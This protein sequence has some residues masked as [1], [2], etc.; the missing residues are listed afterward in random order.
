M[1][2][3]YKQ[4]LQRKVFAIVETD[5]FS[6]DY[7][8]ETFIIKDLSEQAANSIANIINKDKNE[9]SECSRYYKVVEHS[10]DNPYMLQPG[11]EP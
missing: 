11:F 3:K 2:T 5:N 6:S 1:K 7:P 9:G 8:D 4:A 10:Y